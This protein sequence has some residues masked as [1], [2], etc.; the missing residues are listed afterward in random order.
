[1]ADNNV[2][3]LKKPPAYNTNP[4]PKPQPQTAGPLKPPVRRMVYRPK[5]EKRSCCRVFCCCF[6]IFI[7]LLIL[8]IGIAIGIFFAWFQP[9]LPVFKFRPLE[10]NRFNVTVKPDGTAL[11]DSK[12]IVRVEAKN[13]NSKLKIYYGDTEFS[14]TFDEE[15]QMG[16]GTLPR[17]MQPNK[18]VTIL[19]VILDMDKQVIDSTTGS[20]L[21]TRVKSENVEVNVEV[22]T[23]VGIGIGKMK[24]GMLPV[25]I[26]CGGIKLKQL[27]HGN[28]S[29][30]CSYN[31]LRWITIH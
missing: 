13:P 5:R 21:K 27:D 3:P 23:K 9:K 16:T 14:L 1:M 8:I 11:L 25:N 19:K 29:P 10:L 22:K 30:K 31:T 24:I 2:L 7:I 20:K 4:T 26:N 17:F 18:N 12:A 28:S 6:C 15:T